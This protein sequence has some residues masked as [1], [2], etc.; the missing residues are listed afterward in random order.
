MAT[1]LRARDAIAPA[2]LWNLDSFYS[3]D[4]LWEA[5]YQEV[6][7]QLPTLATF[8][9]R[10]AEHGTSVLAALTF[11][12]TVNALIDRLIVYAT[13]RRDE[14][15][16]SAGTIG[17]VR[18]R[19][20]PVPVETCPTCISWRRALPRFDDDDAVPAHDAAQIQPSRAS[21]ARKKVLEI[22]VHL[23]PFHFE[24]EFLGRDF[25]E[26]FQHGALEDHGRHAEGFE[27]GHIGR[28]FASIDAH[29]PPAFERNVDEQGI[30]PLDANSLG[31]N[32]DAHVFQRRIGRHQLGRQGVEI[33]VGDVHFQGVNVHA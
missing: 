15:I 25:V 1:T 3:S 6:E 11:R 4:Q 13:L 23:F 30:N 21:V 18:R 32:L 10:I 17:H 26:R 14:N 7:R 12:D 16:A 9:G 20:A 2:Y 29:L 27:P 31:T 19:C 8:A 5:D 24:P 28:H 33:G 22:E